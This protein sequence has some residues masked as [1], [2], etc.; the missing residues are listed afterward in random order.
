MI[1]GNI[2]GEIDGLTGGR[3]A[4]PVP[5][6]KPLTPRQRRELTLARDQARA[7]EYWADVRSRF[8]SARQSSASLGFSEDQHRGLHP[9][10]AVA[11]RV[12]RMHAAITG[13]TLGELPR[14]TAEGGWR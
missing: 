2:M 4:A 5:R 6:P 9:D 1:I 7:H 13:Q 8:A 14:R 3:A 10:E 12:L 11:H